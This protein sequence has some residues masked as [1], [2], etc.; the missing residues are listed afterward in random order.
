MDKI[1]A[2][3]WDESKAYFFKGD[4]YTRYDI[5]GDQ[6]DEGYPQ[7]ISSGWPG[8]FEHGI[9]AAVVWP[10]GKAYFFKG[11]QY[12]R[13]DIAADRA[14]EGYPQP[15]S[16]GWAGVFESDLDTAVVWPNGKAYFFKGDQYTRYDIAA[17][18]ADEGYPQAISSGWA[19]VFESDLDAAVVWPNGKAYFFKGDQYIRYDIAADRADDGYPKAIS[20]WGLPLNGGKP[21]QPVGTQP[22][23]YIA[24]LFSFDLEP[25]EE[26]GARIVRCCE[27]AL[28]DG[29]MG[30]KERHD[31]YR[32]FIACNQETS[33]AKAEALTSVRTSCAMFVRAVRQWCGAPASG[34]YLP[35]TGMFKSMGN[36][37]FAHPAFVPH[38]GPNKPNRGD[39][40]YIASSKQSND[41]HTGIF[42]EEIADG[43]WRTAEGGGGDGTRCRLTERKFTGSKFAGEPRTVW[44]WFDCTAVGLPPT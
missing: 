31:F 28:N 11:D 21:V 40:F 9:D 8:V 5:A 6:A 1:V 16:S 7:T 30:E 3:V 42:I 2:L 13:Y 37:S 44:G 4:E 25:E 35:G 15:I 29:P 39:Y 12:I 17:D 32:D 26:I 33:Q 19:G 43:T 41:G 14:D 23:R 27:A 34:P 18:Q 22:G 36:V 38:S 24:T 10:N 20:A